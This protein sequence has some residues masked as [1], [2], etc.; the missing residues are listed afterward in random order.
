M[1]KRFFVLSALVF[2]TSFFSFFAFAESPTTPALL[3]KD[4]IENISSSALRKKQF[5]IFQSEFSIESL[6]EPEAT[7]INFDDITFSRNSL[8]IPSNRYA[9][10]SFY[11]SYYYDEIFLTNYYSYSYPNSLIVGS[12]YWHNASSYSVTP[13]DQLIIDFTHPTKDVVFLWGRDG[14]YTGQIGIYTD[15]N[16]FVTAVS[17]S[18]N[19]NWTSISLNQYSQRIKRLVLN[20]PYLGHSYYGF[21]HIDNFQFAPVTTRSPIG[22]LDGVQIGQAASATGWSV[23]P[24]NPSVSNNV[25]CYVDGNQ[26]NN[27]IGR[28]LANNPSP[29]VPHPGNHRFSMPIP[30]KYRDG[31]QHQIN[32]YGLDVTGGDSPTLL[33]NSPKTFKFNAPIGS[34]DS[35]N[36]DGE[37]MGWSLD[38]DPEVA[39][40]SNTVHFYIDGHPQSG[41][42]PYFAGQA[43]ANIPRSDVNTTTGHPGD[44]GYSFSIPAHYRD[45][46]QH[47]IYAYGIDL[48]G[49]Q[50]RILLGSPKTFTLS[51]VVQSVTFQ[52]FADVTHGSSII[53]NPEGHYGGQRIFP[54]KQSPTDNIDR[55]TVRVTAK[56]SST[57]PNIQV[58]FR[59]FDL[60][61]PSTD[62]PIIDWNSNQGEDNKGHVARSRSGLLLIPNGADC[63]VLQYG[64]SCSTDS[65]GIATVDFVPTMQPG[66]NFAV[67]AS[68]KSQEYLDS[69]SVNGTD[70]K[71][72][73]GTAIP[74]INLFMPNVSAARTEMLT[75]WRRV[76]IELDSMGESQD[77]YIDGHFTE[78]KIV[79]EYPTVIQIN[80]VLEANRF[81]GGRVKVGD[82]SL[83]VSKSDFNTLQVATFSGTV[84]INN[85][86]LF[87]LY[88]D[89]DF[90]DDD[91][92]YVDGD[93]G[94][95]IPLPYTEYLTENSDDSQTNILAAA[96]V[97]PV[98]SMIRNI[99]VRD[100][101]IFA[102]NLDPDTTDGARSLF[103]D[104]DQTSTNTNNEFWTVYILGAYQGSVF[105]DGDPLS[106]RC[107]SDD[108]FCVTLGRVDE[109][110]NVTG[111]GS[112]ALI[113]FETH[114]AR[115]SMHGYAN[116]L[117]VTAA[118]EVGHLFSGEHTDGA[119]MS[120]KYV[121]APYFSATTLN[122][123]RKLRHP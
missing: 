23:D 13:S 48:T 68:T 15:N 3:P 87:R 32:C 71:D 102:A 89:D 43:V 103:V 65:N 109:I 24:D 53:R 80:H 47:T 121:G 107:S 54:D 26:P 12:R 17:V 93:T 118:H 81:M 122:K 18:L 50:S 84:S 70:L 2:L 101:N 27:F 74:F 62:D 61:D 63:T 9:N 106:K 123:I 1:K 37:A 97:H 31:N 46:R 36:A 117:S 4:N 67:A 111:E 112:G 22:F 66:D 19:N 51:P 8:P 59:S 7:S 35:V 94:E 120:G 104:Q 113:Y 78:T 10:V 108:L 69:I 96:Y 42:N 41:T 34:L 55:K 28:V 79:T 58:F 88:D 52:S 16:Q 6:L 57:T 30:I 92:L 99:D 40:Q 20:R 14:Y 76:H 72:S 38:P 85:G 64:F 25:D 11:P 98:Y 100:D 21:I 49:D 77:N 90:D 91:G 119:V 115:E 110:T 95:D 73:S 45:N 5:S 116:D 29:D 56:I 60:D 114:R 83:I 86:D 105:K 82:T 39:A 33:T 75:V 44:H